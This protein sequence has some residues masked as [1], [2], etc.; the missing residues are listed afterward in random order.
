MREAI[1]QF[2]MEIFIFFSRDALLINSRLS[3]SSHFI[4]INQ[5][6]LT[7][8]MA[9]Q[10]NSIWQ[11]RNDCVMMEGETRGTDGEHEESC[12]IPTFRARS[13]SCEQSMQVHFFCYNIFYSYY[14]FFVFWSLSSY[15]G[16]IAFHFFVLDSGREHSL[17]V[18]LIFMLDSALSPARVVMHLIKAN[19]KPWGCNRTKKKK[20][21]KEM[22][23]A[24]ARLFFS[25]FFGGGGWAE[26]F[27]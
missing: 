3:C 27:P 14:C 20:K 12:N 22:R 18:I 8:Q 7:E 4:M 24:A 1:Q 16:V 21:K 2:S 5:T 11:F 10:H 23:E 6:V 9:P 17:A 26:T 15:F 19:F 13:R 25:S